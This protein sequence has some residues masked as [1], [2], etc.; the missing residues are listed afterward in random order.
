MVLALAVK[1]TAGNK[2][3]QELIAAARL[4]ASVEVLAFSTK[5]P[6]VVVLHVFEPL[7]AAV[8][9]NVWALFPSVSVSPT[10]V[11]PTKVPVTLAVEALFVR[12]KVFDPLV[13][14]IVG[15]VVD[16]GKPVKVPVAVDGTA[17]FVSTSAFDPLVIVMAP[18]LGAAVK[19][20][21]ALLPVPLVPRVNVFEPL[22]IV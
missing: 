3:W 5:V 21:V 11:W 9:V 13:T 17:L 7:D 20:P 14:V 4:V 18:A 16:V 8:K 6:A 12:V 10:V 19:V 2:V 22:A 15:A 1:P